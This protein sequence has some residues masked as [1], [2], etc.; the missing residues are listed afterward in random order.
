MIDQYR[1]QRF[2]RLDLY[3]ILSGIAAP[4]ILL[5]AVLI[6]AWLQPEYSHISQP[7]SVLGA[8]GTPFRAILSYGGLMPAG[9]LTFTFSIAMFRR[10][11]KSPAFYISSGLVAIAGITRCFAGIFPCDPGCLPIITITGRLHALFGFISLFT[12]SLAPIVMAVGLR[13]YSSKTFFYLS[14]ILGFASLILFSI[15]ASQSLMQYFGGIQRLL[16]ISTYTWIIVVGVNI[17]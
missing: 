2:S 4:V 14:L 6:G 12:G 5:L 11:K 9:I 1:T 8:H 7:I 3:L 15:L 16:L 17:N 13:D 10:F